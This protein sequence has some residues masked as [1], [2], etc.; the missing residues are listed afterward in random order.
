MVSLRLPVISC[1]LD[2]ASSSRRLAEQSAALLTAIG[3]RSDVVDLA[4][5]ALPAFDNDRVFDS[6]AFGALHQL[7]READGVV[8]AFP[9][10]NWAPSSNV[11]SLIEAT[12]ATG[13]SHRA[14]WFDKVITFVCAAGLPHSYMATGALAQSLMLDFKCV[15][16]PYTAYF[17]ERDWEA[18]ALSEER[19]ARLSK[20]MTVHAELV[21]LLRDRT[22]RSDWEV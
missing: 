15:V 17:S 9:I 20:T 1:S 3:H 18:D 12:G 7:I 22:Y 4:T 6:D 14:A 19:A 10:Y 5:V 16:N 11:K 8:L 13:G 21:S 2:P